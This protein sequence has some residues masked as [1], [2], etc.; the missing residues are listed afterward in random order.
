SNSGR[1]TTGANSPTG[2]VNRGF[3]AIS[4]PAGTTAGIEGGPSAAD[5]TV[6]ETGTLNVEA[7][8]TLNMDAITGG[9]AGGVFV[10]IGAG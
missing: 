3:N 9:V 8:G 10:G 5:R 4:V 6:I 2:L 1:S 7:R